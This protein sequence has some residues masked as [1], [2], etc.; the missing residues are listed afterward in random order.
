MSLP[1][2]ATIAN[3]A[4]EY[5]ATMGFFP[6]D[7]TTLG[8]LEQTG[9][10]S[11]CPTVESYMKEQGLFATPHF[12]PEYTDTLEFDLALV[13]PSISGPRRPQDRLNLGDVASFF[14]TKPFPSQKRWRFFSYTIS[15]KR[16]AST[17]SFQ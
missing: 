2:R 3:M 17:K 7:S 4:P 15:I 1:D 8:Y 9:R 11:L 14:Y 16:R 5:G 12:E 13:R 10:S 6:V